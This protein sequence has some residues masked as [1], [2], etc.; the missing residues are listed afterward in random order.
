[1]W[2]KIPNAPKCTRGDCLHYDCK[3]DA[4]PCLICTCN[5]SQAGASYGKSLEYESKDVRFHE[6][7]K[8]TEGRVAEQEQAAALAADRVESR[9]GGTAEQS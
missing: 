2:G 1:M 8:R 4:Y 3:P 6:N 9:T 7:R 5:R